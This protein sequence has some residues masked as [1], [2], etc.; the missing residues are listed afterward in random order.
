MSVKGIGRMNLSR[1]R[2]TRDD[3]RARILEAGRKV[4]A[5]YGFGAA[6]MEHIRVA[7]GLSRGGLYHHFAAKE[8]IMAALV[9]AECASLAARVETAPLPLVALVEAGSE[10]LGA[11]AAGFDPAWLEG[12]QERE[13]YLAAREAAEA[14]HLRPVIE[15]A[16]QSGIAEG[17]YRN[18][19]PRHVAELFLTVNARLNRLAL[20]EGSPPADI[21]GFAATALTALGC[22]LG[23]EREF[24]DL[25]LRIGRWGAE[26]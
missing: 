9:D 10:M 25:A 26:T 3:R 11:G 13:R 2:L 12:R 19:P 4:F 21:A 1:R 17:R 15:T 5:Q 18:V 24:S 14:R 8:E 6:Q 20:L 22:L 7:A 23:A 16:L